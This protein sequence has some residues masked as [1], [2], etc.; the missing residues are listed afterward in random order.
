MF[1]IPAGNPVVFSLT[2]LLFLKFFL[3]SLSMRKPAP[4]KVAGFCLYVFLSFFKRNER[5]DYRS[6]ICSRSELWKVNEEKSKKQELS[7]G[8]NDRAPGRNTKQG[9]CFFFWLP[10][11]LL[12]RLPKWLRRSRCS[13]PGEADVFVPFLPWSMVNE[14]VSR[15]LCTSK[16]VERGSF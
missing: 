5:R 11:F 2:Q 13:R 10:A 15:G 14:E 8:N 7:E 9:A 3:H 12:Q 16:I 1:G 4:R 6:L